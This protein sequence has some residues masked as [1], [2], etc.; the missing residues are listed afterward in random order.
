M[1]AEIPR[2]RRGPGAGVPRR[3]PTTQPAWSS[4]AGSP[5]AG[6]RSRTPATQPIPVEADGSVRLTRPTRPADRLRR[7]RGTHRFF[8][9]GRILGTFDAPDRNHPNEPTRMD[10][11]LRRAE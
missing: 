3:I 8:L 5:G 7:V 6:G 10:S 2:G 11:P 9:T 4:R 1:R